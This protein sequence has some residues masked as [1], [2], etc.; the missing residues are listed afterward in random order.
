MWSMSACAASGSRTVIGASHAG[1]LRRLRPG[2]PKTFF[3]S[4][5]NSTRSA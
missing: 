3:C 2:S 4:V 5:G 1:V